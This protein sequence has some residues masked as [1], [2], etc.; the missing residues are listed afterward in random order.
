[1]K[2]TRTLCA[3]SKKE[4]GR[5]IGRKK[6]LWSRLMREDDLIKRFLLNDNMAEVEH[7]TG[8]QWNL[9]EVEIYFRSVTLFKES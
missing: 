6:W 4:D 7:W 3:R 2:G 1:M 9:T 5:D 8:L